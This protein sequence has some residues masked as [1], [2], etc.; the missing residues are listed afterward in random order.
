MTHLIRQQYLNVEFEGTESEGLTLQRRLSGLCYDSL[1]PAVERALDRCSTADRHLYIERLEIDA[2]TLPLEGLEHALA[3]S[4]ARALEKSLREEC[5]AT[6]GPP[7]HKSAPETLAEAFLYFLKTGTLPWS[8]RLPAGRDLEQALLGCWREMDDSYSRTIQ[9]AAPGLLAFAPVR[10]RLVLQFSEPFLETMLALLSSKG[11]ETVT[12]VLRRVAGLSVPSSVIKQLRETV[13]EAAFAG[14]AMGGV[15]TEQDLVARAWRALPLMEPW[16]GTLAA[17]LERQWP[18]VT[19]NVTASSRPPDGKEPAAPKTGAT[20]PAHA[21]GPETDAA[22]VGEHPEAVQGI[23]VDNAGLVLLHPFLPA[24]FEALEVAAGDQ[25]LK[26][27]RALCLL[28]YLA[29][30]ETTAPEYRTML[31]KILCNVPLQSPVDADVTLTA[32]E[33]E[34]CAALLAAAVRHWGALGNSSA[35]ALRGTFLLRQGKL[36]LR[37]DGEWLLQVE[38]SGCDI[39]LQQLPWGLSMIKLPWMPKMVWAEWS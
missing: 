16:H 14:V 38:A 39:L 11:L 8:F 12:D 27:G 10:K 23:Y 21:T 13:W 20:L 37:Q 31:P 35:D 9:Y 5:P 4:V 25:L 30:G 28:H 15:P 19:G 34:E 29:S 17:G 32:L 36:S 3:E 2:G 18:G 24:L 6:Q 22:K 1:L 26:P 7:R 33:L